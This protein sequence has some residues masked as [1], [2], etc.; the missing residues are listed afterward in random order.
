MHEGTVV[1]ILAELTIAALTMNDLISCFEYQSLPGKKERKVFMI[2]K[3]AIHS[4]CCC[5]FY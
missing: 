3:L 5:Y 2:L 4:I 1:Y